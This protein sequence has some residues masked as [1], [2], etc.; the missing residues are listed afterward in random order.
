MELFRPS[1]QRFIQLLFPSVCII[2]GRTC[3]HTD[4]DLTGCQSECSVSGFDYTGRHYVPVDGVCS[5][6]L[7]KLPHNLSCCSHCAL[8]L[9]ETDNTSAKRL[10]GRCIKK[11]PAFDYCLSAFRYE[12]PV[13]AKVHQLKFGQRINHAPPLAECVLQYYRCH[14]HRT[15]QVDAILPVPLHTSRLRQRGFNQATELARVLARAMSVPILYDQVSRR[16]TAAQA[17]LNLK[18]RHRNI[19]GAFV[20]AGDIS[21]DHVLIVDDVVTTGS[22]VAELASVLKKAGVGRVGVLSLARAPL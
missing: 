8:P 16:Q 20:V 12:E 5:A 3:V 14:Q 15:G 2:C 13:V 18:Q 4:E 7:Q 21:F 11:S 9:P 1:I 10:C 17:R 22:T 19:R 6:C